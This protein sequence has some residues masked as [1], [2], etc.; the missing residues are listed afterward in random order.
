M[1][2]HSSFEFPK[3]PSSSFGNLAALVDISSDQKCISDL[4]I[5]LESQQR[6]T[7]RLKKQLSGDMSGL[8]APS[9][10][11]N[12][13]ANSSF[14]GDNIFHSLQNSGRYAFSTIPSSQW[15]QT[16][17]KKTFDYQ[18][19]S[20]L[21][22]SLKESQE[23][24][25]EL[26]KKLQELTESSDHQK[27]HFRATV[28]DLKSKLHDTILN[29][30]TVLDLRQKESSS[31]EILISKL[32]SAL[33]QLQEQCKS[34]EESLYSASQK[35]DSHKHNSS[36]YE[37]ALSQVRSILIERE[38]RKGLAFFQSDL[39][40]GQN[41]AVV[42]HTLERM[43]QDL[44]HEVNMKSIR[45]SEL[46]ADVEDMKQSLAE[47][48]RTM[49]R[50]YQEKLKKEADDTIKK[51]TMITTDHERSLLAATE[52]LAL[53][54]KQVAGLEAQL[55][56]KE[57][58]HRQEM[59]AKEGEVKNLE[60]ALDELKTDNMKTTALWQ[61]KRQALESSLDY[62]QREL[63][64][65]KAEKNEVI[66]SLAAM[67]SRLESLQA[68]V[69]QLEG[70]LE[71]EQ[72]RVQQ[73][74]HREEELRSQ[75]M[76]LEIQLSNK[77]GDIERLERM[78]EMVKQDFSLQVLEKQNLAS[79]AEHLERE[80]FLNQI[81]L[82]SAQLATMTEKCNRMTVQQQMV[83]TE[84]ENLK[85]KVDELMA[86]LEQARS[87]LDTT[88]TEKNELTTLLDSRNEQM[89]RLGNDKDHYLKLADQ[90]ADDLTQLKVTMETM[91]IQLE[92]KEKIVG[93][94]K[95][96]SS[97]IS[98]LLEV[99]SR[100]SDN[101]RDERDKL[102][103]AL[104]EKT[105]I[106]AE[107]KIS[108]DSLE[109]TLKF[110]EK[111]LEELESE[112]SHLKKIIAVK[113]QDLDCVQHEKDSLKSE[114]TEMAAKVENL[115][116]RKDALKKELIR[117]KNLHTKEISKLQTQLKECEQE[118]KLSVKA[119]RSKDIMDNKAV[120][121]ADKIQKE[122]TLKRSEIDQLMSKVH[123]LEEKL[124]TVTKEK[125][126]VERDKDSLK[127]SLAKS[128]FHTKEL[129]EK[130]QATSDQNND[131][132]IRVGRMEAELE[133]KS[134]AYQK[135]KEKFEQELTT[136]KRKHHLDVKA[137][138]GLAKYKTENTQVF[139]KGSSVSNA[140]R[141]LFITDSREAN[142]GIN[143]DSPL[144]K[145]SKAGRHRKP[146]GNKPNNHF[147]DFKRLVL[148]PKGGRENMTEVSPQD[149]EKL[150]SEA[151]STVGKCSKQVESGSMELHDLGPG[152]DVDGQGHQTDKL[153]AA[154]SVSDLTDEFSYKA[155]WRPRSYSLTQANAPT[156]M[157]DLEITHGTSFLSKSGNSDTLRHSHSQDRT[158]RLVN[159]MVLF[160]DT[161]ELCRRLEEKI[162]NLTRMGGNLVKENKDMA[163]LI[164]LQGE[165]LDTVK[166]IERTTLGQT[167]SG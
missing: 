153:S 110:Q 104:A 136:L 69:T 10:S 57:N 73:Q 76:N 64:E 53:A 36:M 16:F 120:K 12:G 65:T 128:L 135:K 62:V 107:L 40:N 157:K 61:E 60:E 166:Q 54:T 118:K 96:Q 127:K 47:Q 145:N 25:M 48:E 106:F 150:A 80:H 70:D 102:A 79:G 133:Q 1:D 144:I 98:Q 126:M 109:Q 6:E 81:K 74:R 24:V 3:L 43:L 59:K 111:R 77:Q 117:V 113:S 18:P 163:D 160:P 23:Q 125:T 56:D 124:D 116:T 141:N 71:T 34:Q 101:V 119:L 37:T 130:L 92:E 132:V 122:M 146:V 108:H 44:E 75:N 17:G 28:E 68:L 14:N 88:V 95:Q 82:L 29:R 31:Q 151:K 46:E 91:K 99:N 142:D 167:N 86:K 162:E 21:E 121:F 42:V 63:I 22:R 55:Q 20:H 137:V 156:P 164:N 154:S 143:S 66:Q 19:P 83:N 30:D 158:R 15:N 123:R 138:E 49:A 115:K 155:E 32:H 89:E 134:S 41:V 147:G 103:D 85:T 51:V 78:L 87:Q 52:K 67:E 26:R 11:S 9:N 94:F 5:Q 152:I 50:D 129:S 45:V 139:A 35:L 161:Q 148:T 112:G 7:D 33:N 114:L 149:G 97:S 58:A 140:Q 84:K 4:R 38:K 27:R 131:L 93:T 165:K 100:V 13:A 8:R 2:L 39:T 159:G 72:D 105:A 90:R